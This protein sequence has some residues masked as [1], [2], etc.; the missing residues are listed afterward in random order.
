MVPVPVSAEKSIQD[1]CVLLSVTHNIATAPSMT[2][3]AVCEVLR[4][5]YPPEIGRYVQFVSVGVGQEV[6]D[7]RADV[8]RTVTWYEPD[9]PLPNSTRLPASRIGRG[10]E[11]DVMVENI[12]DVSVELV[13]ALNERTAEVML[14]ETRGFLS[15]ISYVTHKSPIGFPVVWQPCT[16]RCVLP[17]S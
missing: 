17:R 15:S 16:A 3:P 9:V 5:V 7:V 1:T 6:K 2:P 10:P 12:F 11:L 13:I 8:R 14:L 4:Y